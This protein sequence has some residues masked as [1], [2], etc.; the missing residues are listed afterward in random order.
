MALLEY[1]LFLFVDDTII[2]SICTYR[3]ASVVKAIV[4]PAFCGKESNG[5]EIMALSL[6][7]TSIIF[8]VLYSLHSL[9][10]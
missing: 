9:I 1:T 6:G 10:H 5:V 4:S 8:A 2:K 7:H 3:A